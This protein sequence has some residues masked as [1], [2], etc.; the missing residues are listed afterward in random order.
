MPKIEGRIAEIDK[1]EIG[2]INVEGFDIKIKFNPSYNSE[3]IY[4]RTKDEGVRVEFILGF[5]VEGVFAF[6]VSDVK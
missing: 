2:W 5:R 1:P 6:S 4:R 3:R